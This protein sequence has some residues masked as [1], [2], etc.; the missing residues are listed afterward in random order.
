MGT[1]CGIVFA[2]AGAFEVSG[3]GH[4]ESL[5]G[6]ADSLATL[7]R[8]SHP[9]RGGLVA[10]GTGRRDGGATFRRVA[11]LSVSDSSGSSS[12][13]FRIGLSCAVFGGCIWSLFLSRHG[14]LEAADAFAESL[15]KFGQLL[16]VVS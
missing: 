2:A 8:A 7:P 16:R 13:G 5:T 3:T 6:S 4:G 11:L 1:V 12:L 9:G 15:A 14:S 10:R